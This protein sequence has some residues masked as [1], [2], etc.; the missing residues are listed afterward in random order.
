MERRRILL[1]HI[2]GVDIDSQAVEVTKLSLLL[3]VLE[4]ESQ[5]TLDHQLRL[6]HER[7]LPDLGGNIKCGNSLIGPDFDDDQQ[8]T[9]LDDEER[10]RINA[11]DWQAEFPEVFDP[12]AGP[13]PSRSD[14]HRD[15]EAAAEPNRA[16]QEA[17]HASA[18]GGRPAPHGRGSGHSGGFDAVIGNPPYVNAWDLYAA[19]P[20]VR[21]YINKSSTFATAERHWDL[22]ILF[23]ERSLKTVRPGGRVSFIIPFSYAIQKYAMASRRFLLDEHTVESI[24]DLRGIRVFRSVPVITIIPVIESV[25]AGRHHQIQV[26]RPG[27]DATRTHAGTIKASHKISQ[28]TLREQHESMW[29]LDMSDAALSLC[30]HV[31]RMSVKVGEL[32][33]VNYG[34]QMS[35]REKGKFGK[36][37]VLR[38]SATTDTCQRTVSGRNLYRYCLTWAGQFVERALSDQMY[39]PRDNWFFETQKLMVR[40][41]T[42][43]H[44]LELTLDRSG[45]YCDHT[46]LCALRLCDVASVTTVSVDS[47]RSSEGYAPE[48]LLGLLASRLVSAVYYL[49]LTG[50]GV[51]VGGGFHTYP[52][53]IRQLPAFD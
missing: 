52:K 25:R 19:T 16:G 9:L 29:R 14:G 8:V 18:P 2:Y 32:C 35:S 43:T 30:R 5:R 12:T 47:V 27:A 37:F 13:I 46:I 53:T 1:E 38:E 23:L 33:H 10:Y 28:T 20:V 24:A 49:T 6:F 48:L 50:E 44:R 7:A 4:G 15:R 42:G 40:D 39:G 45:M 41:I 11:F 3:K 17:T 21:E 36:A 26:W 31:E 22:Y 34:A 51:R